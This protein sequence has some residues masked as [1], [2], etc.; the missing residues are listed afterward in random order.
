MFRTNS[1]NYLSSN[2]HCFQQYKGILV[3][4]SPE[5]TTQTN[6][7]FPSCCLSR[8]R[9]ESW[10]STI[11]R[12]MSLI[13]IRIRNSLPFEWL[14]T[15]TRFE[16]EACSNSEMG[17]SH[18]SLLF[19]HLWFAHYDMAA[20]MDDTNN[21][22]Q[23][24]AKRSKHCWAQHVANTWPPCCDMLQHV[25]SK[26]TKVKFFVQHFRCCI[27]L[28]GQISRSIVALGHARFF[29]VLRARG[30]G[31]INI[32]IEMSKM[33]RAFGQPVEHTSQ[34]ATM[35][36]DVALKC[37]ERLARPSHCKPPTECFQP[38]WPL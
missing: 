10:C 33:L 18:P 7:P 21:R 5:N 26:F 17:Y 13:C 25:G 24:L 38:S 36:Q 14:C 30:L 35:L 37:C 3:L 34:H 9:S 29:H 15:G 27:M 23:G 11:V 6:G 2:C 8:F 32:N 19:I 22:Y 28:F 20:M 1:L 31:H 4:P 12:E 16:N